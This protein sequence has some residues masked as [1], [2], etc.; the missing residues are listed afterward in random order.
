MNA[1]PPNALIPNKLPKIAPN[2]DRSIN[3]PSRAPSR[4]CLGLRTTSHGF[5]A[6]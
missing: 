3:P 4:T 5:L 1:K 6:E 2:I